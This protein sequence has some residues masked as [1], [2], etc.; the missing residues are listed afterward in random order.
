MS[1]QLFW[2]AINADGSITEETQES[3]RQGIIWGSI[4]RETLVWRLGMVEWKP[5]REIRGL[6]AVGKK[7]N[8]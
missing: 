6:F 4:T 5:A 2:L 3:L 1:R 7:Q 8:G